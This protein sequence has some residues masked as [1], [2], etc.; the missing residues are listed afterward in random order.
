MCH[1]IAD[2]VLREEYLCR[3]WSR[4]LCCVCVYMSTTMQVWK[5]LWST[6]FIATLGLMQKVAWMFEQSGAK[7]EPSEHPRAPP[8]VHLR[9][10]T[11]LGVLW[12][13]CGLWLVSGLF[14]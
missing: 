11:R 6:R 13:A 2:V 1:R 8:P 4:G 12:P 7:D 10:E 9:D 5:W 3:V 14:G